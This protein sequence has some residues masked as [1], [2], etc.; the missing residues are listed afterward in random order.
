MTIT[1]TATDAGGGVVAGV[2]V[3]T[4][5][6]T[7]WHPAA[8]Q[9]TPD[10]HDRHLD[11]HVDR[12]AD[13]QSTTIESRATDDSGNLETPSTRTPVN[14]TCPCSLWGTSQTPGRTPDSAAT[15]TGSRGRREVPVDSLWADHRDALLQGDGQHRDA[16]RQ[17]LD[18]QRAAAGA[19]DV[20]QRD[21]LR[22][23][24]R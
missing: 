11:V 10:A 23:G 15:P 24:R 5:G 21:R 17:S 4:D 1:G 18:R 6:G 22:A 9:A 19:G 8:I 12:P 20:H 3:S 2:E 13:I 7:T 16:R 14:V